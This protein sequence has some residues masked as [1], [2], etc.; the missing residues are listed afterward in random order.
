[1]KAIKTIRSPSRAELLFIRLMVALGLISM[2]AFLYTF[3]QEGH[4]QRTALYWLLFITILF[5]CIRI[6]AEWVHYIFIT[7]PATPPREKEFTVDIFTTYC[8]GEPLE[9][10]EETLKAMT[11][12]RYP[13]TTYLCD[14]ADDPYLKGLCRELGIQHVTR[15]NRE[16]AKAGNINNALKQSS[17]ELCV[18]LDP[19]HVPFPEFLDPIVPHFNDPAIGFVQI[20]QAYKNSHSTLVAKGAAQQTYQF[21]GPM[22]MTMNRY[23]TVPAIGANC[24]FRRTALDSIDGHAAGLAEDMNTAMHLHAKGWKSVYVPRVLARGLVPST[25]S[26]YYKQQLK[27]SRGVFE[28]LFTSYPRL[29]RQL[30]WRQKLHYGLASFYYL[31]GVISLINFLIP[32]LFLLDISTAMVGFEKFMISVFPLTVAIVLIRHFVQSW[33]MEERERG[34]HFVGGLLMI[35]TWWVHALGFLFAI[36]RKKV[37]YDP[38]PKGSEKSD[39]WGINF[40]NIVVILVSGLAIIYGLYHDWNP[41]SICMAGFAMVNCLIMLFTIAIGRQQGFRSYKNSHPRVQFVMGHVGKVKH[42][43]WELRHRIYSGLRIAALPLLACAI[44]ITLYVLGLEWNKG[45]GSMDTPARKDIF[46]T[47][48]F[49]PGAREGITPADSVAAFRKRYGQQPDIVSLYLPWGDRRECELPIG[50]LDSIY[51]QG[52]LPMITWEPWQTLFDKAERSGTTGKDKKV[53]QRIVRGS[54]DA[55]LDKFCAGLKALSRPVFLR[56]AHEADNPFYPWSATGDNTASEFKAAWKY[57]HDYFDSR[58]VFNVIWVWNPWKAAAVDDYFPGTDYVDWIGVTILNYGRKNPDSTWYAMQKL[59]EPFHKKLLFRLGLP[60]MIAEMGSLSSEGRQLQ[61]F[62]EAFDA[63][64]TRYPEIKGIVLFNAFSDRNSPS[65][66]DKSPLNW[67]VVERDSVIP[68]IPQHRQI[69]GVSYGSMLMPMPENAAVFRPGEQLFTGLRGIGYS[70]GQNWYG[71]RHAFRWNELVKDLTEIKRLGITTIKHYGPGVYDRNILRAA[72]RMDM[73]IQYGFWVPNG[74][75]YTGD[76]TAALVQLRRKIVRTVKDLKQDEQIVSWNIG[77]TIYQNLGATYYK[78]E[79]NYQRD[80]YLCWLRELVADVRKEDPLRPVTID[81]AV[82]GSMPEAVEMI[83]AHVPG[84]TG[85]GLI[86]NEKDTAV[87]LIGELRRPWFYGDVTVSDYLRLPPS[88]AGAFISNWKDDE[89]ADIATLDGLLD[90]YDRKKSDYYKLAQRWAGRPET[91]TFPEIRI[92]RTAAATVKG[93][94]LVYSAIALSGNSWHITSPE[95]TGLRFEWY[96]VRENAVGTPVGIVP[97]G[98]GPWVTI[99]MP[100]NPSLYK[101]YLY[102]VKGMDIKVTHTSL[103]TPLGGVNQGGAGG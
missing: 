85:Y 51:R 95:A 37:P 5:I 12:I 26:A 25:L 16:D 82:T 63:I 53:F 100:S 10:I 4:G 22:M 52:S 15:N 71:N 32:V 101:L 56:F 91:D 38:T 66:D 41:Y 21:Y 102:S 45:A 46:L 30:T 54:Y 35:G 13:H 73:K 27:W 57:V 44:C 42:R 61:W 17:G 88:A 72:A 60:V 1:M 92:L 68:L 74:I 39:G 65:K 81:I 29:F 43:F 87:S 34:F 47:G 7:V 50:T 23:G 77:N 2:S 59:Y 83:H 93:A 31:S 62:R 78:P 49:S 11:Q 75:S 55:F 97:A 84:I 58:N 20:V 18:I 48:I 24:T 76:N 103:N 6:I 80:A 33:V 69:P 40:P 8:P 79:A 64:K 19:D 9:M 98:N 14:E 96:L 99:T 94:R 70:R 86:V 90:S 67:V 28:L 89:A 36:I 3:Y